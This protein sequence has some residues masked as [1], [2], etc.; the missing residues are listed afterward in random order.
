[1]TVRDR[2]T[3]LSRLTPRARLHRLARIRPMRQTARQPHTVT[4]G[5]TNTMTTHQPPG[6]SYDATITADPPERR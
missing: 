4:T 6:R 2:L 1:M 5:R 3:R